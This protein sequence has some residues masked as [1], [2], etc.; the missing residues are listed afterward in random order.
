MTVA[1]GEGPDELARALGRGHVWR[2]R[3]IDVQPALRRQRERQINAGH[4]WPSLS[5]DGPGA[6][7][8]ESPFDDLWR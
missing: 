1:E 2:G 5:Q 7:P 3:G 4:D 8:N 6:S